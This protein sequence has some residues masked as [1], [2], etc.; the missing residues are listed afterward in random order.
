[1]QYMDLK[2]FNFLHSFAGRGTF[3]DFFVVFFA[4]YLSY[5]LVLAALFFLFYVIKSS[6]RLR[7]YVLFFTIL[8]LILSRGVL[9]SVIRFFYHK[10]RPFTAL[11]FAPLVSSG[12]FSFPSGHAAF[13]FALALVIFSFNKR[14]GWWFLG[15]SF[16]NGVARVVAGLHWPSD[17]LGGI[18]VAIISFFIIKK[19]MNSIH[20]QFELS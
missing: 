12:S 20:R 15:L 17:I 13:F 19:L 11:E 14:W 1:M 7:F 10:P 9:V 18:G 5:F 2:T 8:T 3:I 4:K 16:L 6:F